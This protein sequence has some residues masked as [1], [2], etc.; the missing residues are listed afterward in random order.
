MLKKAQK[1]IPGLALR[2]GC[3]HPK[4]IEGLHGD[5]TFIASEIV[6]GNK[7]QFPKMAG[8]FRQQ[9]EIHTLQPAGFVRAS[10]A[11]PIFF[12]SYFIHNI[13]VKDKDVKREWWEHF[14]IDTPPGSVRL[15]DGG[16][17]SNFPINLFYNSALERPRLPT[18]GIDLDDTG[19]DKTQW[20]VASGLWELP[21]YLGK[22]LSALRSYYDKDFLLQNKAYKKGIGAIDLSEFNWLNFFLTD[23]EKRC[24]FFKG[25]EAAIRFLERFNWHEYKNQ[26]YE[27]RQELKFIK[28]S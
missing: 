1:E 3:E 11:I 19:S 4:G 7:I 16:L 6:T 23:Q 21:T 22:M 2:D 9:D 5:V 17:L 15:V 25:A 13:P 24:L 27:Y 12:E 26:Q 14:G 28:Q 10:M 8:L 18:L 20:L